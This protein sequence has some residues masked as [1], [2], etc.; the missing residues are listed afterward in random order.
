MQVNAPR[1]S[2]LFTMKFSKNGPQAFNVFSNVVHGKG[3]S[4]D[5]V[6]NGDK[7]RVRVDDTFDKTVKEELKSQGI[8][9]SYSKS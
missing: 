2:G 5:F 1:F 8:K 6:V 3:D 7:V 4:S 9:F